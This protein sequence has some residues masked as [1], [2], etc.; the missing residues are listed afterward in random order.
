[1]NGEMLVE[2][3]KDSIFVNKTPKSQR[4]CSEDGL[5]RAT[6]LIVERSLNLSNRP[7]FLLVFIS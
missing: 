2:D 5:R 6:V 3:E 4:S 1:V 7:I